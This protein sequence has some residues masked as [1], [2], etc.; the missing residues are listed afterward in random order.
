MN[1][2]INSQCLYGHVGVYMYIFIQIGAFLKY[3]SPIFVPP[4]YRKNN[5]IVINVEDS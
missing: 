2:D 1:L 5:K 4:G 3:T